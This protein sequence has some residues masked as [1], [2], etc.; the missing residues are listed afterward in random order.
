MPDKDFENY[1]TEDFLTEDS[2]ISYC[3]RKNI[4]DQLFWHEWLLQHPEKKFLT[5]DAKEMLQTLS[6]RL[7]ENEYQQELERIRTA[8]SSESTPLT[9]R[10]SI[11]R[12]L[13]W[14]KAGVIHKSKRKRLLRYLVP[15]ILIFFIG[16]YLTL[17]YGKINTGGLIQTFNKGNAPLVFTLSDS[18]VVTLVSHSTLHYPKAF[19]DKDRNVYLD[20]E[21]GFHVS[22]NA[23]H[24]FKVYEDDLVA[25]VLGTIFN[26]KK[27]SG[28]SAIAVELL[29]GK[30]KVETLNTE[31][32]A[33]QSMILN[34][35]EKVIYSHRDK[36]LYKETLVGRMMPVHNIVFQQDNFEAIA[37]KIKDV[38]GV[39]VI[40]ESNKKDWRFTGEFHDITVNEII[41]NICLAE[42][43]SSQ[44]KGDTILI[45]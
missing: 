44:V 21:A 29:Q 11:V 19:T 17:Q 25:T 30:V 43:L 13:N 20:G 18:T 6:L 16:A 37:K 15:I 45:K 28:D 14:N 33:V 12:F 23:V 41:E 3:F 32:L 39:T 27:M 36:H 10:P 8:I 35:N 22:H 24:P 26:V 31:G 1:Q 2:F 40:N 42:Q 5:E 9:K 38:F 34:P 4:D 7:P